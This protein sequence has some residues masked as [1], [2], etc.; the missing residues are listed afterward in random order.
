MLAAMRERAF[1]VAIAYVKTEPVQIALFGWCS[2]RAAGPMAMV[3]V[4]VATAGVLLMSLPEARDAEASDAPAGPPLRAC[5]PRCSH[6]LGA[7][8]ACRRSASAAAS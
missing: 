5:A 4:L 1:V 6:R 3:A 8:F 2:S 7:M